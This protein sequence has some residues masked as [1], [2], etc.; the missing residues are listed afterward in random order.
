MLIANVEMLPWLVCAFALALGCA[1]QSAV[2]FGMAAL[3]APVMVFV[4]PEW[5]PYVLTFV[6]LNL[7]MMNA[8]QLRAY[9]QLRRLL[10]AMVS[11]IPGTVVGIGILLVISTQTL[12]LLVVGFVLLSVYAS[13]I[14]VKFEATPWRMAWAGLASG[15]MGTTTSIGGPPMAL[16]MQYG[17]PHVV[18]AN[19]SV[20][21]C[22]SCSLSLFSYGVSGLLSWRLVGVCLSFLPCAIVGFWLGVK[23]RPWVDNDRFR[24]ILLVLCSLSALLALAGILWRNSSL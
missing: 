9:A 4:R 6:A 15:F 5:V 3:A 24:P 2:G 8:W 22:Y 16:V 20:Y 11:R 7:S 12:Q 18:R 21:F 23:A 19:L 10:P 13:A 1:L 14:S 17:L